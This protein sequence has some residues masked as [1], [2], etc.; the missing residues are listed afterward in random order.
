MLSEFFTVILLLAGAFF[1]LAGTV[2]LLRFPDVYTRL[3]ALTKAD[4][5]GL[6]LMVLGLALQAES[7]A[8]TGKLILIWLCVLLSSASVAHLIANA[9]RKKGIEPW[10]Q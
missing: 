10:K 3:H 5:V 1:F 4:N 2:G 9:A 7:W 6:G 8:M